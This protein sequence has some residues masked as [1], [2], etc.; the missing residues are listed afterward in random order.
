M[1]FSRAGL[2][3]AMA[4]V[5]TLSAVAAGTSLTVSFDT[6][7]VTCPDGAVS[8]PYTISTTAADAATV[9]ESLRAGDGSTVA[10]HDYAIAAGNASTGGGWVF[11]GRTKTRD[12]VFTTSGVPNGTYELEVCV[13]Q[14][15]SGGNPNKKTC[16]VETILVSCEVAEET[17]CTAAPFGEVIGNTKISSNAAAEIQFRGDFGPS[18]LVTVVGNG[19]SDSATIPQNGN[20]CTYH[21]NWKFQNANGADLFGQNGPGNYQVTVTGNNKTLQFTVNV[22]D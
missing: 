18:A 21:A 7:V 5:A 8:A 20:S 16:S 19:F 13:T 22:V 14:A 15:G 10:T 12:G 4:A 2:A 6:P 17:A 1:R 3:V 11:A 9:V